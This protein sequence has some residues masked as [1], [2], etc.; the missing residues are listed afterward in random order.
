MTFFVVGTVAIILWLTLGGKPTNS[1]ISLPNG[2]GAPVLAS[3]ESRISLPPTPGA[4]EAA[5]QKEEL[6]QEIISPALPTASANSQDIVQNDLHGARASVTS[7]NV[8]NEVH[9]LD[10]SFDIKAVTEPPALDVVRESM[11]AEIEGVATLF[12]CDSQELLDYTTTNHPYELQNFINNS[13]ACLQANDNAAFES[14][15]KEF[16]EL[17]YK[18]LICLKK[19]INFSQAETLKKATLAHLDEVRM[20]TVHRST[21]ERLYPKFEHS[22]SEAFVTAQQQ[23]P[24]NPHEA[25]KVFYL[26]LE[27]LFNF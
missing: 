14:Y 2:P 21:Y 26:L 7:G 9:R 16:S 1:E 8:K 3:L 13:T 15:L 18:D 22:V 27:A 23:Y 11:K 25:S 5:Q 6:K 17:L 24:N 10:Q 12:G 19:N 4:K 20:A